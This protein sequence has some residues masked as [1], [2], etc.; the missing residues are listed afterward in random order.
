MA[1][2]DNVSLPAPPNIA[3]AGNYAQMLMQGLQDLPKQYWQGQQQQYEQRQRDLFQSGVPRVN[4]SNDPNAPTDYA[5][6]LRQMIQAGG[7]PVAGQVLPL[8]LQLGA[9]QQFRNDLG[10]GGGNPTPSMTA[11]STSAAGPANIHGN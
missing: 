10:G 5:A 3:T 1:A 8:Q 4:G 11:S 2:Y 9:Q 6:M 7:A